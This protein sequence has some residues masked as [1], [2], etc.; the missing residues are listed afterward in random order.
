MK[1]ILGID[2]GTTR[3]KACIVDE[4]GNII[5]SSFSKNNLYSLDENK[6]EQDAKEIWYS[7]IKAVKGIPSKIKAKVESL[8]ISTQGGTLFPFDKNG[9]PLR[10]GISWMDLR[11]IYLS[12][13][14]LKHHSK[15]F[16]FSITGR[17]PDIG[18]LPLLEIIYLKQNEKNIFRNTA[19]YLFVD[20]L[21]YYKMTGNIYIDPSNA[22]MTMLYDVK[23]NKWSEDILSL[24]GIK[25]EQLPEILPSGKEIGYLKPSVSKL[26]GLSYKVK[27]HIGGHDQYC[28]ALGAGVIRT[29][30]VMLSCGTAWAIVVVVDKPIFNL[31]SEFTPGPHVIES[32]YGLL[33]AISMAG[34]FIDWIKELLKIKDYKDVNKLIK[35]SSIGSN[36][37]IIIPSVEGKSLFSGISVNHSTSSILRASLEGLCFEVKRKLKFVKKMGVKLNSLTMVGGAAKNP[38]FSQIISDITGLNVKIPETSETGS[39]G[40]AILAGANK[41][42]KIRKEFKPF[43]LN[44]KIYEEIFKKYINLKRRLI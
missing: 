37:I 7:V 28:A 15:N 10:R 18:C 20:S 8:S 3:V 40:A 29:G 13:K 21:L 36:G 33:T 24:I 32:K 14:L 34:I 4:N 26:L 1:Y 41:I 30:D 38:I 39:L 19:K 5:S 43:K 2:V 11:A 35:E 23:Q 44:L 16:F 27:V 22:I 9:N 31:S 17:T 12:K 25:K 6:F 42:Y